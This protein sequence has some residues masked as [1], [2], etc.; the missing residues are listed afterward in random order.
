MQQDGLKVIVTLTRFGIRQSGSSVMV[1]KNKTEVIGAIRHLFKERT[2][3]TEY[4]YLL[5]SGHGYKDGNWSVE[6]TGSSHP[7]AP[8]EVF[9]LWKSSEAC[10]SGQCQWAQ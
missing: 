7:I 9:N 8:K 10:K 1:P 2:D 4:Y 5:F 6:R 3:Q